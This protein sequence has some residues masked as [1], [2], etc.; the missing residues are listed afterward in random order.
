MK[1]GS[2]IGHQIAQIFHSGARAGSR[3]KEDAD[4][5]GEKGQG[6]FNAIFGFLFIAI[7]RAVLAVVLIPLHAIAA[8]LTPNQT[9]ADITV[10][11]ITLAVFATA[12]VIVA[13]RGIQ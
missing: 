7:F 12:I 8:L 11:I 2:Y 4:K 1:T 13:V 9:K 10:R 5:K 3:M 6:W